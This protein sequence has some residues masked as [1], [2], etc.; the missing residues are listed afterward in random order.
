MLP[1]VDRVGRYFPLTLAALLPAGAAAPTGRGGAAGSTRAEAA[2]R[3][4]LEQ[5]AGAGA[6]GA[7]LLPVAAGP[8]GPVPRRS[9]GSLLVD[10]GRPARRRRRAGTRRRCP[11][12]AC[13]AAMLAT[14]AARRDR[15]RARMSR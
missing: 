12:P 11:M 2:G 5:D 13:F 4:A 6:I 10:R 7:A 3:A 9:T 15:G 8:G 1:S 14:D